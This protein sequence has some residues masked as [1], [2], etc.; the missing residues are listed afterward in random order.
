MVPKRIKGSLLTAD[1]YE[2][3]GA[4][5]HPAPPD[6]SILWQHRVGGAMVVRERFSFNGVRQVLGGLLEHDLHAKR[7]DSLCNATLGVLHNASLAVCTIGQGLAAARNLKPKHAIKQV[8]RLLSNPA[9]N[10]DNILVR[11][12]PY[13]IG[14]RTAIVVALDWT[15]FDADNQATII[16][17][18]I[19]DHGRSTPLVWLTVDKDT[20]KDHRS[21]Y[22]HRVL[23]RLAELLPAGIK[24]CVVADRGFGDQK[25]YRMLTEELYFDYVIRFRGNIAV[26][27]TTGETRTAAAWL[28]P[29]GRARVLR[30]AAVTADRY[31]VGTV[32]CVQDTGMKQAWCLAASSTD[33]TA[34]QLTGYYGRRWGIE[35]GLR[36]AKDLRF[37]MGLGTVHV[38]SPERRDR[39]WLINAFAVVLLTLLGAAG[40]ALGYD[41]MLKTNTV[42][43]RV[44]SLF[45]QGC[46]LYDLIPNMSEDWLRP[47][48]QRFSR[49]LQE[50]PLFMKIFGPV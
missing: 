8:D 10:V 37:G 38:K 40:E 17:A 11:W 18:L 12:V 21:L 3:A 9:I 50:Q 34:K 25:L 24:V 46:M 27:A 44:H 15:D 49:M 32:V 30:G 39:L 13:I 1:P 7:V 16:L 31:Q 6:E 20:L 26:T 43:R 42:K 4:I 28:R 2:F 47:L 19:S 45:R 23:V 48:M 36:D 29:G 41:R 5:P 35:C 33:A 14:A 22:E